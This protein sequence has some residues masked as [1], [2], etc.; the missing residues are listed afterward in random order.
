MR[1][2]MRVADLAVFVVSG[3]E[4]LEVQ[5]QVAWN[6]ADELGLPRIFFVNKL[7]RENSSVPS[8]ARTASRRVRE[9]GRPDRTARSDASTSSAA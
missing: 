2:A 9:G 7:D 5:T 3:V 8:H 4:G 1:A 6:Y